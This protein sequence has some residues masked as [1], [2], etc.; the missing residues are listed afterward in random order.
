MVG[1]PD[2]SRG[3]TKLLESAKTYKEFKHE[4]FKGSKSFYVMFKEWTMASSC[5]AVIAKS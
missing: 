4:I 2:W 3:G 1:S 5:I